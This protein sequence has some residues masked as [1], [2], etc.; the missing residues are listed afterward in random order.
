MLSTH[1]KK[2]VDMHADVK[3]KNGKDNGKKTK[4]TNLSKCQKH[5]KDTV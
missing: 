4:P 2:E 1:T 5:F 3:G